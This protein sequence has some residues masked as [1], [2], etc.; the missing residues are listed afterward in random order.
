MKVDLH[1]HSTISDGSHTTRELLALAVS[2]GVTHLALTNHDTTKGLTEFVAMGTEFGIETIPG[3]EISAYDFER[4]RRVHI[5]GYYI[6]TDSEVLHRLC[7]PI[8]EQRHHHSQQM[9][10]ILVAAGYDISW[11]QVEAYAV[12]GTG[13]YKQHIMRALI[14]AGYTESIYGDLYKKLFARGNETTPPGI[15]YIPMMYVDAVTAVRA[16]VA[17]GGVPVLAHPGQYGNFPIVGDLAIAGLAGIEV[18]HPSH[19]SEME[20]TAKQLASRYGL[21]MSG[22]T[23]FHGLYGETEIT[24]GSISPGIQAVEQLLERKQRGSNH[25]SR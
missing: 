25:V 6:D 10:Q 20:H 3:I 9:V 23:D 16:V 15:A 19:N 14:E 21:I 2:E 22:G 11:D 4:Q 5:L 18:W 13:V 24:L 7:T 1:V 17:A 8:V 12:G